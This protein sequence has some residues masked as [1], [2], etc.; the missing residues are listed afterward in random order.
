M[1]SKVNAFRDKQFDFAIA[2]YICNLPLLFP[3]SHTHSSLVFKAHFDLDKP[4]QTTGLLLFPQSCSYSPQS[5][6]LFYLE[7]VLSFSWLSNRWVFLVKFDKLCWTRLHHFFFPFLSVCSGPWCDSVPE[8]HPGGPWP[9]GH[10]A[11]LLHHQRCPQQPQ[12]HLDG[13]TPI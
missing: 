4:E 10:P 9:G 6:F 13:D 12:H 8:Q 3:I 1:H 7:I 11:V 2:R 5:L